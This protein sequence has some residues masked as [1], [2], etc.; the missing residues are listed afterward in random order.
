MHVNILCKEDYAISYQITAYFLGW[1]EAV[2]YNY[3]LWT[4]SLPWR[5]QI[6]QMLQV[7]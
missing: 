5:K 7:K 6:N 2:R 4:S 1:P 3:Y